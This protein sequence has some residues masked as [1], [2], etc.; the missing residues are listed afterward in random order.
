MIPDYRFY[1]TLLDSFSWFLKSE[2][3]DAFQE[4]IDKLN[5]VPFTSEAAEKGTAF[6]EIVD[7]REPLPDAPVVFHK[8]FKFNVN[9]VKEFRE[10]YAYA[11]PQVRTS[12]LLKLADCCVELYGYIDEVLPC[13]IMEDVKTTE[14]WD[15]PKYLGNWQH[16]V[17]PYCVYKTSGLL[18]E[19]NYRVTNFST[20]GVEGYFFNPD[21]DIPRLKDHC[22]QLVSFI[23][24]YR[25]LITD[26]NLFSDPLAV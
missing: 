7:S 2:R 16:I 21:S 10:H 18:Y 1:A 12:A 23:R 11:V 6:N 20:V 22:E 26:T 8:G 3:E 15:F 19:F 9:L 24:A 25:H 13:C 17:Y 5:R 4:F 14:N